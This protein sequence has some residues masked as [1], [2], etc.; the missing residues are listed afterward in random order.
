ME[1]VLL[2]L[3][4]PTMMLEGGVLDDTMKKKYL[5]YPH[6]NHPVVVVMASAIQDY[7]ANGGRCKES[8]CDARL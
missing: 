1:N 6:P 8:L 3:T 4:N 2:L 7:K 5:K